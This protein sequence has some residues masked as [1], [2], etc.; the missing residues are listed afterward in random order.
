MSIESELR[1]EA[2]QRDRGCVWPPSPCTLGGR[3]EMAHIIPKGSG[4]TNT[5]D[6][7]CMLCKYHHDLHDGREQ[8]SLREYRQLLRQYIANLHGYI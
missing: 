8:R 2:I 1:F 5:I 6:N 3:L 7:V 4:G